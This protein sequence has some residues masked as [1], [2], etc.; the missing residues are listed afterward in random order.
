MFP[1]I[2][3]RVYY[4]YRE[5]KQPLVLVRE[6]YLNHILDKQVHEALRQQI[7]VHYNYKGLSAISQNWREGA[8]AS[9]REVRWA[10]SMVTVREM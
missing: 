10:Q 1:A 9:W 3:E 4:L 6:P 7:T 8:G 5:R 2:Q